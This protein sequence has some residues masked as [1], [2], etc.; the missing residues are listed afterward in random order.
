M[1]YNEITEKIIGS[2]IEAHN[3]LGFLINFNVKTIKDG[4]K[5]VVNGL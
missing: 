1:E 2:A 5:R 3:G 4:I